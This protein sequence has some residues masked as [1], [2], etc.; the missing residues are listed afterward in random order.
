MVAWWPGDGNADDI[1]GSNGG[2]LINGA[3]FAAGLVDQA[4]AFNGA[5][6]YADMGNGTSLQ[7][8][9]GDFTADVWVNF[10]SVS[11]NDKPIVDKMY[12]PA[13]VN[14]DGWRIL[15]QQDNRFWFCLGGGDGNHCGDGAFTV[16]ST[17]VATTATW[18]HVAAVKTSSSFSI[19]VNGVLE[20]TRSPVPT[21]VDSNQ[22]DLL[23]GGT[24]P[25]N[26]YLDG[27]CDEVELFNRALS[28]AEIQ[29]IYT[30]GAAGK[31]KPPT[32][33]PTITLTP[34]LSPTATP[35]DTA[36]RTPTHTP[37]ITPTRTRT[38]TPSV[39]PTPTVLDHF[40]CYKVAP[41]KASPS[42]TPYPKFTPHLG[43]T[44]T[45]E[46]SGPVPDQH[47]MDFKKAQMLCAPADNS[48]AEPL[49][50]THPQHLEGYVVTI[51][52]LPTP[53]PKPT[54]QLKT[55]QNEYGTLILKVTKPDRVM[56]PSAKVIGDGGTAALSM[57][58]VDHFKCYHA[59][60]AK[61]AKHQPPF[62]VWTIQQAILT[63]QLG[64]PLIY[65]LTKP[66]HFCNPADTAGE[67]PGA[68]SHPL[69]LVCY[70]A[71]L[72]KEVPAQPSFTKTTLSTNN[73]WGP[74]VLKTTAVDELC[75]PS[76]QLE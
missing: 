28:T 22:G 62:P 23:V 71:K 8:S 7:V 50:P 16:F 55:I 53:Q 11:G 76:M 32:A 39:T 57:P 66:K 58:T 36:T 40:K 67:D 69:H 3:T 61:A 26:Y 60:V 37:T 75:V 65:L 6:Q 68:P 27:L 9:A 25:D 17:T 14:V 21:F 20:D 29:S 43:V 70:K 31:C 13:G 30:A 4:F 2:T 42:Q 46:F 64:G 45:D 51:S 38:V 5:S 19:Y 63:D 15:K 54:P 72:A 48:G 56:V 12:Q 33:T 24:L 74:E 18:Y 41:A 34:S 44:V 73:Q 52:K 35:T 59:G 1:V 49:A 10:N 47:E